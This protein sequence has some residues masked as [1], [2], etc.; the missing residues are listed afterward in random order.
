[1]LRVHLLV[2]ERKL[3]GNIPSRHPVMTWL[4]ECVSDIV[5]KYMQSMD[6]RTGYERLFCK[7]VHEEGL[8]FGDRILWRKHSSNDT[9]EVLDVQWAEEVW[10]GQLWEYNPSSYCCEQPFLLKDW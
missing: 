4:L 6:G 10:L 2:L 1:M 5:T 3:N 9:N 7:Q 8:A